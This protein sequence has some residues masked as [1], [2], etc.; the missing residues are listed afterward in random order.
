MEFSI[1]N[2][3]KN[4]NDLTVI[5]TARDIESINQAV[6]NGFMPIIKKVEK[7][8]LIR[9]KYRLIQNLETG[10]VSCAGDFRFGELNAIDY[11]LIIDWTFYYPHNFKS[12]FAAYLIPDNL[13]IGERVF[14]EDLIEDLVGATWNQ[15]DVYRLENCEAIWDGKRLNIE[16]NSSDNCSNFIG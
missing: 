16:Y 14:I 3:N 1:K 7:S 11:R 15:G 2:N 6:R 5:K 13:K 8:D 9:Q 12:P 10:E 4:I